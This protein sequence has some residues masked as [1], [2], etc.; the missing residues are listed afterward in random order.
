MITVK[1]INEDCFYQI[2]DLNVKEEQ[3][4]FIPSNAFSMAEAWLYKDEVKCFAVL[5]D[6]TA[7]GFI[8]LDWNEDLRVAEIIRFMIG[9]SY[10]GQGFGKE[11]ITVLMEELKS[12]KKFDSLAVRLSADNKTAEK[13]FK[14]L[15][16]IVSGRDDVSVKLSVKLNDDAQVGIAI[17]TEED[18]DQLRAIIN[19]EAKTH[20]ILAVCLDEDSF[21]NAVLSGSVRK[22]TL[23][24]QTI[25]LSVGS[26]VLVSADNYGYLQEIIT[27]YLGC[28]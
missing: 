9:A 28:W 26:Y 13:L 11:S 27:N 17:A 18:I 16:F 5:D 2:I 4:M 3:K 25:G 7:V 20:D 22:Y 8:M 10:Q 23:Y 14:D 19:Y 12:S 1:E 21:R 24:G 15:S 6:S